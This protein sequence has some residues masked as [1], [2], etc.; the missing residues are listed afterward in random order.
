MKIG[1]YIPSQVSV[2]IGKAV[3]GTKTFGRI[4]DKPLA[5]FALRRL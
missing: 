2:R 5:K 1:D 4:A 3:V